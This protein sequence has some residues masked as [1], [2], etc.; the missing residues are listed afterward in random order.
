MPSPADHTQGARALTR[1]GEPRAEHPTQGHALG[2][3]VRPRWLA[4]SESTLELSTGEALQ[5]SVQ[6]LVALQKM[7][8]EGVAFGATYRFRQQWRSARAERGG[9]G[10]PDADASR[11]A[12]ASHSRVRR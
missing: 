10:A 8:A 4:L 1:G 9:G 7:G 2:R 5:R 3:A 12:R 11:V 6:L